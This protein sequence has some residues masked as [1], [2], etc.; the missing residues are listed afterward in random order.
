M[1]HRRSVLSL[2]A[3]LLFVLVAG[4]GATKDVDPG[5]LGGDA[6][7]GGI[8]LDTGGEAPDGSTSLDGIDLEPL[9]AVIVIDTT[10]TPATPATQ[11]Y[12]ATYRA[13]DGSTVDVSGTA[14]FT[15]EDTGLGSFAGATFTSTDKLPAG[16]KGLTTI[17]RANADGRAA[18][19]NVTIV[20]LR[21]AADK[22]GTGDFFFTVPYLGKPS[23]EKDVLKFGTNIKQ[24]D[25]A[26]LMDTTGSMGGQVDGLKAS[27]STTIFPALTKAIPSV[28]MAVAYHDD[29]PFDPYGDPSC[30][31]A[32]PGDLPVGII[33]VVTTDL[34]KAQDAAN[35]LETHCGNDGPEAQ[36]PAMQ[37]LLTGEA[38]TWSGGSVPKH[39][40]ATGTTGG[41]DFRPGALP[42]VTLITDVDWH[43]AAGDAYSFSTPTMTTVKA[44]FLK[45]NAR[46]VELMEEYGPEDQ[47]NEL[48]DAT[49]SNLPPAAFGT[50]AAG[51]SGSCCTDIGG[52]GRAPTGPGGTCR[53]NYRYSCG[54]SGTC[55][56]TTGIV[57]A[58][59]AISAGSIFDVTATWSNDPANPPLEAGG[60]PVDA[61]K[62]IKALRAMK[63]GDAAA[64][65]PA[66]STKDTDGD[67]V[68]DTFVGVKVGVPVCFE[69]IPQS[70]TSVPPKSVA[71]FYNAFI[72]VIGMPGAV[73]LDQRTVLFLVPPT[74]V[75]R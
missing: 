33:Q 65:C 28:G 27:L 29:Y 66:A 50:C 57:N 3:G 7:D 45:Q 25:V 30:G 6:G 17:I 41:V 47:G 60:A 4:C 75:P 42:V 63:E 48:S 43:D 15:V 34:K 23:P 68:D 19:T 18:A 5:V 26:F 36:I 38:L 71:Q 22:P 58:I 12:K 59:K 14:T 44:A 55:D 51:G 10:T 20:A 53:L 74:D 9:N 37:H 1:L 56:V 13:K 2:H 69:V 54:F 46:F 52:K 16:V 31:G 35:K 67:G 8:T 64:G 62:F 32:L 11:T 39:T 73:K 49:K 72:D 61:S 21:R 70:N 24:V 40:P